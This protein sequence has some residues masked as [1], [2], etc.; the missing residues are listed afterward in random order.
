[1]EWTEILIGIIGIVGFWEVYAGD[2]LEVEYSVS[3]KKEANSV[4]TARCW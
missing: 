1:M 4:V 2:E 3:D